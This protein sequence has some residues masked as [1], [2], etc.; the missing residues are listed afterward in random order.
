MS[1]DYTEYTEITVIGDDETGLLAEITGLLYEHDINVEHLDQ[2]VNND[3]FR[4]IMNVDTE[5]M[6]CSRATLRSE[7]TDLCADLNVDVQ[8]RFASERGGR[9]LAV[10]VT[11][12]SHGLEAL[13]NAN[14]PG[15]FDAAIEVVIGNHDDLEPL[16][17]QHDVPFH[18]IG[19]ERGTRMRTSCSTCLRRTT[20]TSSR[21]RGTSASSARKSYSATNTA[22]STSTRASSRHSPVEPRTHKRSTKVSA[23]RASRH[24]TSPR[25]S[26]KDRS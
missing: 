7:L 24:I 18:D 16:A 10:L 21:S 13:F 8:L 25:T 6:D 1:V 5:G 19:D 9:P 3:L 12:E 15:E 11:K 23:S 17:S 4:M 14:E 2:A 22:S 20:P 26:T